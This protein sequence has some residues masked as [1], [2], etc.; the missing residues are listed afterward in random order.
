[1]RRGLPQVRRGVREDGGLMVVALTAA[2][3]ANAHVAMR[4]LIHRYVRRRV[5]GPVGPIA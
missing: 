3:Q 5:Y 1:M 2:V 4:P